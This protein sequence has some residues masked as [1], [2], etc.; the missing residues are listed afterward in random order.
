LRAQALQSSGA[1]DDALLWIASLALAMTSEMMSI[2]AKLAPMR[3]R[4]NDEWV[5]LALKRT[6]LDL[7]AIALL[8]PQ[9]RY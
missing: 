9:D 8:M 1:L 3:L 7:D 2:A 5:G 4:G 6:A